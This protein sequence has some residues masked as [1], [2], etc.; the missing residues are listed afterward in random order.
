MLTP[1]HKDEKSMQAIRVKEAKK[2]IKGKLN[3]GSS[4]F[5]LIDFF[6]KLREFLLNNAE[7]GCHQGASE[8]G[9]AVT[10]PWADDLQLWC[11]DS[12]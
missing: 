4:Y 10:K 3:I 8:T 6:F 1:N 11:K 12:F 9:K 2:K 5:L 7:V